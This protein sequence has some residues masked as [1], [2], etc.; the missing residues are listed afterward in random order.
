MADME[1]V[2]GIVVWGQ[3]NGSAPVYREGRLHTKKLTRPFADQS[4][5]G[6]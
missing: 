2:G 3:I 6:W 4:G 1:G 5:Q